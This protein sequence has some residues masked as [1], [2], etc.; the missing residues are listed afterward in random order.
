M[1]SARVWF[2]VFAAG[3]LLVSGL[4]MSAGEKS[5]EKAAK[6]LAQ[7]FVYPGAK[8]FGEDREGA[9]MYQAKFTTPDDAGKVAEWYRKPLKFQGG[10]GISFNPGNEPGIRVSVVDD[11]RQPGKDERSVGDP[12]PLTVR[13]F[14]KKTNDIVVVAVVSRGQDEKLTHIALTFLDNKDQ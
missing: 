13:T 9:R 6:E 8:K 10:E 5:K 2:L 14:V 12:R 3:A 1:R 11:S 4:R 7:E